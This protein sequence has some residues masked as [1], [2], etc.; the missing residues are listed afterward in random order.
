MSSL[1][2][3]L[4]AA[5]DAGE[6]SPSREINAVGKWMFLPIEGHARQ[7][8]IQVSGCGSLCIPSGFVISIVIVGRKPF[9]FFTYG[10]FSSNREDMEDQIL[11]KYVS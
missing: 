10:T 1:S 3:I 6:R 2:L 7:E 4:A 8:E 5:D 11:T 9:S